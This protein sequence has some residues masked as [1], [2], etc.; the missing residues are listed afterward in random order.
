MNI[1]IN[2]TDTK[3]KIANWICNMIENEIEDVEEAIANEN[4]YRNRYVLRD[5]QDYLMEL[6]NYI[7]VLHDMQFQIVKQ[8]TNN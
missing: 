4:L 3:E 2:I 7:N 5:H 6:E 8:L 1:N